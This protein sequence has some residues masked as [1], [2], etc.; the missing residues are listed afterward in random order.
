M[1]ASDDMNNPQ[2]A[3]DANKWLHF[4]ALVTKLTAVVEKIQT[5]KSQ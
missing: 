3:E 5:K 4:S 2:N 1:H